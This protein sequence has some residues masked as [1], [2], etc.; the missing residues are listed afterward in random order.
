MIFIS[1]EDIESYKKDFL[2]IDL[3]QHFNTVLKGDLKVN[4][5]FQPNL[6]IRESTKSLKELT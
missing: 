5:N 6:F 1:S 3:L 4:L 2:R